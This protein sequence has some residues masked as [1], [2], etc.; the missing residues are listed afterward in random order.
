M[1]AMKTKT[2]RTLKNVLPA[3]VASLIFLSA[4]ENDMQPDIQSESDPQYT[5]P[6]LSVAAVAFAL[7]STSVTPANGS[8]K[9]S[10][11]TGDE[12]GLHIYQG[13]SRQY[14]RLSF[15]DPEWVP[16]APVVLEGDT[17]IYGCYPYNA[18]NS[19][20]ESFVIEHTSGTDYLYSPMHTANREKPSVSLVMK[21]ALALIVFEF[22]ASPAT[23]G[24][25]I[26]FI[27]IDGPGLYSKAWLNL[28]SG[29]IDYV[30][31]QHEP[32]IVYGWQ[33][34]QSFIQY[35]MKIAL[36]AVPV[37]KVASQGD[38]QFNF[39]LEDFKAHWPVPV[40]TVWEAGKR[41]TYRVQ[42]SERFLEVIDVQVEDRTDRGQQKIPLYY[43][44]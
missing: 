29:R 21:H 8:S 40:G 13:Q 34:E 27:S 33:L 44:D 12:I 26:D 10:F 35:G 4:C 23:E 15:V 9:S 3:V 25:Q 11:D 30:A 36:M 38:I 24:R 5:A 32:A 41:Y 14:R 31:G 20:P 22:E 37:D 42:A 43:Y 17:R 6:A 39:Y 18:A 7:Q 28:I 2:V 1:T 19:N 16:D